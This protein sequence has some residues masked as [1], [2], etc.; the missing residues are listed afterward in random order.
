MRPVSAAFPQPGLAYACRIIV[1]FVE[2]LLSRF[3]R[4]GATEA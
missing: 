4:R 2:H 3:R 1:S